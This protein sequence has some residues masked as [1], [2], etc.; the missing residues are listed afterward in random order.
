M[1]GRNFWL[2]SAAAIGLVGAA[3]G[4]L[5]ASLASAQDG[6][7][8]LLPPGFDDP[9]PTP[10]PTPTPTAQPTAATTAAPPVAP[11]AA[12]GG[13]DAPGTPAAPAQ[14]PSVPTLSGEDLAG[15]PSLEEL[16]ALTPDELDERLGLKPK[17]DIP[18]A[19]RRSLSQVGLLSA[20]EGG[21]PAGSLANQPAGL[22][23]AVLAGTRRPMVSRWGHILM[24]RTLA[25]RL[26]APEGMNPVEFAALRMATLNRMGEFTIARALV[27]DVDTGNWNDALTSEALTAYIATSDMVGVCPAVR[28]QGS[29][30]DDSQWVMMQA[31]C[32]AYAGE[33]A[34]AG[35]Q[36]DRALG[37]EIA[38]PIDVLLAQ[39]YAGAAGRGRRAVSVEW[40]EVEEINP[41]RF[42][43]ANAVG[44]PVPEALLNAAL[45]GAD[46]DYYA[47]AGATAPMLSLEQRAPFAQRAAE[48]GVLSSRAMV[49]LYS[50]IYADNSIGGD[51]GDRA[52]NLRA[53]YVADSPQAR[54]SAMQQLWGAEGGYAGRVMTAFAA[55][56]IPVSKE[57]SGYTGDLIG[58]MLAAGLDRDAARWRGAI[59]DGSMG[60]ALLELGLPG[61]GEADPEAVEVFFDNDDSDGGRGS[62]FL[63]ASLAGLERVSGGALDGLSDEIGVDLSRQTR[64]TRMISRAA[65]VDNAALVSLLAG[66]GMQGS[67]WSKM[68][69][70]HLYHITSALRRVG[71]DAEA[72]MIAAEAVA[73]A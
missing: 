53:A 57:F 7:A 12:P 3:A 48:A 64:W 27:Q 42:A 63:L 72:R 28:L 15:I 35:T 5:S 37:Q 2:G 58:S 30:R 14:L 29:A 71:L 49:D 13:P 46:G 19:A 24:R 61:A 31:V 51:L 11:G 56:R 8:S 65:D 41:W 4:G 18:P 55:A 25:S 67:D 26:T 60:W 54:I 20:E 9:V 36:L 34:L 70:L 23:R 1:M 66:L 73:R 45:E 62:A 17:F 16:E 52:A 40:E 22:V 32:N 10:S 44:E 38:P 21:L 33:G 59:A 69:P 50:R 47:L 43:F 6:P 39:R 68:T